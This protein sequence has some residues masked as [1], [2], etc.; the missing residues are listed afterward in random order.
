MGLMLEGVVMV[1]AMPRSVV[2]SIRG[3]RCEGR[4]TEG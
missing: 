2:Y 3:D 1:M 4:R